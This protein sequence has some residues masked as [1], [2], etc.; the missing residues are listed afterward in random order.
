MK[1]EIRLTFLLVE[2][3]KIQYHHYLEEWGDRWG[4]NPSIPDMFYLFYSL[5]STLSLSITLSLSLASDWSD[6]AIL[7]SHWLSLG[8]V[9][10]CEQEVHDEQ[11]PDLENHQEVS[12]GPLLKSLKSL[13]L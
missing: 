7:F 5:L 13:S 3:L 2:L 6:L 9:P 10:D 8:H 4:E 11:E 12:L 1:L